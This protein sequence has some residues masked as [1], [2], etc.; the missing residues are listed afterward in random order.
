MYVCLCKGI[1]DEM[2]K[3]VVHRGHRGQEVLKKL[4]IGT[5]CGTCLIDAVEK[6]TVEIAMSQKSTLLPKK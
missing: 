1:T 4:G 5:D 3:K 2:I 6:L